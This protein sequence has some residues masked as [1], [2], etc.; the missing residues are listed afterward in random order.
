MALKEI[1]KGICDVTRCKYDVYTTEKIDEL[2]E[3]K[4]SS[5]EVDT[6]PTENSSNPVESG[7][8]FT[9]LKEI[10]D[11]FSVISGEITVEGNSNASVSVNYPTGFTKD[12]TYVISNMA[13]TVLKPD[14]Y[15]AGVVGSINNEGIVQT[16]LKVNPTVR[17]DEEQINISCTNTTNGDPITLKYKVVVM[18]ID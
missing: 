17:L 6:I 18:K 12:N 1:V 3:E 11:S 5:I 2:L 15:Q 8:V 13:S 7:G 9:A 16:S 10:K 4:Q 14:V